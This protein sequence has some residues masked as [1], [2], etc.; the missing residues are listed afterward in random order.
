MTGK[1]LGRRMSCK[2]GMERQRIGNIVLKTAN[3]HTV[4]MSVCVCTEK[5]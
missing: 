2:C 3:I 1:N 4:Y 5:K